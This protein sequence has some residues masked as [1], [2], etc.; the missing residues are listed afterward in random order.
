MCIVYVIHEL[1]LGVCIGLHS[2]NYVYHIKNNDM[3][4]NRE[5]LTFSDNS[6]KGIFKGD[7]FFF[8]IT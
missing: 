5:R 3:N 8:K 2:F 1:N 4:D 6:K 7:V